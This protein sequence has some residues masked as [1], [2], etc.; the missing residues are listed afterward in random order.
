MVVRETHLQSSPGDD[1]KENICTLT[2]DPLRNVQ[3]A[4][5]PTHCIT[6]P[7]GGQGALR[8][9]ERGPQRRERGAQRRR[10]RRKRREGRSKEE[11]G[12]VQ[13]LGPQACPHLEVSRWGREEEGGGGRGS[14]PRSAC[15]TEERGPAGRAGDT[16]PTLRRPQKVQTF[17]KPQ[18]L[19][20]T[21]FPEEGQRLGGQEPQC[22]CPAGN[23][24][25]RGGCIRASRPATS[26]I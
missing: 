17:H 13:R 9:G 26:T 10:R 23:E 8:G 22:E 7:A 25:G 24:R 2:K 1:N 6:I 18:Q 4:K 11:A 16:T 14:G 12:A 5:K 20:F 21:R 15:G 3:T 19:D